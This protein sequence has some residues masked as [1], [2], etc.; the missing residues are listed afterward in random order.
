MAM[1]P[2]AIP[3]VDF[4]I[5]DDS[6]GN[7]EYIDM[8]ELPYPQPTDEELLNGWI[9]HLKKAKLAE[10]N[11]A[12]QSAIYGGFTGGNGHQYQFE[13]KDQGNIGQQLTLLLLDDTIS[14]I[15]WKTKDAGIVVHTRNEFIALANDA[16]NHKR[17]NMGKYW[18]L[19]AQVNASTTESEINSI[20]W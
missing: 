3:V 4:L 19:E 8:W 16:N 1:Y 2:N 14:S 12:C 13:E 18:T 17:G 20:V 10:L 5:R 15:Q 9:K 6:N 11:E 7:G